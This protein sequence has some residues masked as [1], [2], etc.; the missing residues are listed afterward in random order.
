MA[1]GLHDALHH[2]RGPRCSHASSRWNALHEAK[3]GLNDTTRGRTRQQH[4]HLPTENGWRSPSCRE[5]RGQRIPILI[6]GSQPESELSTVL[7]PFSPGLP[8][9]PVDHPDR[10]PRSK[11]RCNTLCNTSKFSRVYTTH[12]FSSASLPLNLPV[13]G[14]RITRQFSDVRRE[15]PC[16]GL[17]CTSSSPEQARPILVSGLVR[18]RR[19][20]SYPFLWGNFRRHLFQDRFQIRKAQ[21]RQL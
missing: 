5:P 13:A 20:I 1:H 9:I 2:T 16:S 14:I 12:V 15:A 3:K 7:A 6:M 10:R 18:P 17:G 8:T 11:L 21:G 4:P 19:E